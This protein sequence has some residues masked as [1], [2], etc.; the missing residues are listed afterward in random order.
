[1]ERDPLFNTNHP[2]ILSGGGK[3]SKQPQTFSFFSFSLHKHRLFILEAHD[4]MGGLS[5]LCCSKGDEKPNDGQETPARPVQ[6]VPNKGTHNVPAKVEVNQ[7][8]SSANLNQEKPDPKPDKNPKVKP[9]D[10]NLWEE[11]YNRLDPKTQKLIP[12]RELELE[13]AIDE[14]IDTTTKKYGEWK[15]GG[16]KI[17]RK[18]GNDINLRAVS[19][20][21]L[22]AAQKG[23][24]VISTFVSFDPTGHGRLLPIKFWVVRHTDKKHSII[25]VDNHFFWNE[26]M[27]PPLD[28][29]VD[30]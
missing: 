5:A 20:S 7:N 18:S 11:A 28:R 25:R 10:R 15:K 2:I 13:S 3:Q 22:G 30:A 26:R 4:T 21:I 27:F 14:V 29:N 9:A 1:M 6:Q 12:P 17:R 19:E 16:L 24:D 8:S 23:K